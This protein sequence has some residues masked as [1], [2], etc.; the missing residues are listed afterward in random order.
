MNTTINEIF[1]RD[2]V[3]M[4]IKNTFPTLEQLKAAKTDYEVNVCIG[5]RFLTKKGISGIFP[6]MYLSKDN[7]TFNIE[8]AKEMVLKAQNNEEDLRSWIK[9][10]VSSRASKQKELFDMVFSFG[11]KN[12][13]VYKV[14]DYQ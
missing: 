14:K 8:E 9:F 6:Y 13:P 12:Q 7:D 10:N 1:G 11:F 4:D 3:E 5:V 2:L